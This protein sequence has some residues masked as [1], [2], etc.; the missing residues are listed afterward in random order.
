MHYEY[1]ILHMCSKI[2]LLA[3]I[4]M[5]AASGI[6]GMY[7]GDLCSHYALILDKMGCF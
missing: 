3:A 4:M 1:S 6:L 5:M 2:N 7:S